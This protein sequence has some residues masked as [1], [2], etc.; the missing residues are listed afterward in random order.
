MPLSI[1]GMT[2]SGWIVLDYGDIIVHIFDNIIREYYDLEGLW[3]EAP[4]VELQGKKKN[5]QNSEKA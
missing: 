5:H 1:E 4:R 2:A 3:V